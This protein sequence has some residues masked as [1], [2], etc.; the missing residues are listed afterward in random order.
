MSIQSVKP[1]FKARLAD[2]G[3]TNEWAEAFQ[4]EDIP[5]TRRDK[6]FHILLGDAFSQQQNQT[7]L[8]ILIPVGV[9]IFFKAGRVEEDGRL[10]SM[11]AAEAIIRKV[12]APQY[13]VAQASDG[14]KD[15]RLS[16]FEAVPLSDDQ[17]NITRLNMAFEVFYIVDFEE[18]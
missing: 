17:D 7:D 9:T 11:V 12:C 14:I 13:R 5:A 4:F 2:A 15:V 16:S 1:Y 3:Y 18:P 8:E 6:A 10:A